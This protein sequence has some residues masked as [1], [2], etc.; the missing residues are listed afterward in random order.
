MRNALNKTH[1]SP[2][3]TRYSPLGVLLGIAACL[4]LLVQYGIMTV[5]FVRETPGGFPRYVLRPDF[6]VSVTGAEILLHGDGPRLYDEGA[7]RIVEERVLR[8]VGVS[9]QPDRL[10]GF[11]HPPFAAL[12]VAGL[13]L[14][15]LS[16]SAIFL[17]WTVVRLVAIAAALWALSRAW[18]IRGPRG[19][20]CVL[21]AL[22]FYPLIVSLQVGQ[23]TAFVLLGWAAGSTA[24]RLGNDRAAGAW[25]A[26][27][28][29]KPQYL[30]VLL[31]AL[32]VMRRWQALGAFALTVG[33]MT[34]L[35]MPFAGWDWP[36]HYGEL[37]LR[38]ATQPPNVVIDPAMMQNWRGFFMRL[39]NFDARAALYAMIA[40]AVTVLAVIGIWWHYVRRQKAEGSGQKADVTPY[41]S[42]LRTPHSA[43]N[44]RLWA[45]TLCAAMLAS[46]HLLYP[47]VALAIVPGWV[48][49]AIALAQPVSNPTRWVWLGWLWVGWALG[50]LV[51]YHSIAVAYAPLWLAITAVG[52]VVGRRTTDDGRRTTDDGRQMIS[53]R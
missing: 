29:F 15:G 42:A 23:T 20:L 27:A 13:R 52:L 51:N 17:V 10:L 33:A 18:P 45:F 6:I 9:V 24:F 38:Q 49:M 22:T 4:A 37:L 36:Y 19:V 44:S 34:L 2:L 14:I 39:L 25:L 16:Y 31:I 30:P 48:I 1:Y 3:T 47:D 46:Y 7:Q 26:L 41:D 40:S 53:D 5:G 32:A 50:F 35:A 11:N 43:L 8:E 21:L 12:V 28:A